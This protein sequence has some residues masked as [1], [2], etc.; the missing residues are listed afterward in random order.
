MKDKLKARVDNTRQEW[1]Q[2]ETNFDELWVGIEDK[3]NSSQ[4]ELVRGHTPWFWMKIAASVVLAVAMSWMV[5][6][7]IY[8][9]DKAEQGYALR[10]I[11]PELAETE[12]YY[13]SQI[14]E[15]LQIIYASNADVDDLVNENMALLDSAYNELKQDLRDN[16]DN[17]EVISAMIQNYRIKLEILEKVLNEIRTIDNK[18]NVDEFAI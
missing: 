7:T 5:F 4:Q 8:L 14:S 12:F 1:E 3:L 10:D 2:Y 18:Q 9:N 15:K 11:S 16:A 6:S 13:A 17:E